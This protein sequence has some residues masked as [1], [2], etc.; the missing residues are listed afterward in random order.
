MGVAVLALAVVVAAIA[1]QTGAQLEPTIDRFNGFE[2]GGP[3]DYDAVGMPTGSGV[4]RLDGAGRFGLLTMAG[5]NEQEYVE[6]TLSD[7]TNVLTDGIWMCVQTLPAS[8]RRVRA[9]L[10]NNQVVMELILGF[11]GLLRLNVNSLPLAISTEEVATCP[12]FSVVVVEY[13]A[14]DESSGTA[15][16]TVD[17]DQQGGVHNSILFLRTTRIGPDDTE[18]GTAEIVWDDHA[19]VLAQD[20]PGQLRIAGLVPVPPIDPNDPGFRGE[21][22]LGGNLN[23][24]GPVD[25]VDEQPPD[26]LETHISGATNEMQSFCLEPTALGGVFGTILA[27]KNLIVAQGEGFTSTLGLTLRVNSLACGGG[28]GA[29]NEGPGMP[30]APSAFGGFAR[31][32]QTNP[33]TSNPWTQ[34]GLDVTE[35]RLDH[36]SPA[37]NSLVTQVLREVAFDVEGF[38]TPSWRKGSRTRRNVPRV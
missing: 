3:G 28:S 30:L 23:C 37:V 27:A 11:D 15:T 16:L 29:A 34:P 32:D 35:F 19:V 31:I 12:N 4:H 17:G 36:L 7:F 10:S 6:T 38:P 22:D 21:W 26:G 8:P 33:A 13:V 14:A 5:D 9:W 1:A 25:C 24:T 20:F 2:S 18:P